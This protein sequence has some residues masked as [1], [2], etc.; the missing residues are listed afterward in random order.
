MSFD[1]LAPHYR[2]M[3]A[4]LAGPRLQRCRTAWLDE[5]HGCRD[6]LIA[7]VGHGPF[8]ARAAQ[9]LPQ[10]RITA[11]DASAGMLREARRRAGRSGIGENRIQFI[12]AT[13][14]AWRPPAESFDAIV[15]HFFLDC[16][17]PD[18]LR[19]V[20]SSLA[21]AARPA[22]RWLLADFTVP[23][24]GLAR[25]RARAVHALMYGFFRRATK[26]RAR[27]VTQPDGLLAAEGFALVRRQTSEWGLLHSDLWARQRARS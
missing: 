24:S 13:L 1:A 11:V 19:E 10:A 17:P 3:E 5:L 8:L 2:W 27:R 20:I 16:F 25:Q 22:A 26:L 9:R 23:A 7:G 14:P 15:T 4:V 21:A 18:E 6:I 12:H